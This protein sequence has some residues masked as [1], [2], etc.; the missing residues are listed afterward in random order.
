VRSCG[1]RFWRYVEITGGLHL[2]SDRGRPVRALRDLE[3]EFRPDLVIVE[4]SGI[5]TPEGFWT[6][7]RRLPP[8]TLESML[9]VT[10]VDPL[11]FEA[12]YEVLTP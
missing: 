4:A 8:Q 6:S 11:R 12:L 1:W 3:Q 7:I 10:V 2:L 5:A 9:T